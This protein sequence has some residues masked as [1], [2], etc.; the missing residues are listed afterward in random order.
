[1]FRITSLVMILALW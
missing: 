1:M